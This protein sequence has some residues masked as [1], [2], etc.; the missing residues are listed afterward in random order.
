MDT[1]FSPFVLRSHVRGCEPIAINWTMPDR[2][3]TEKF[4][5]NRKSP[6]I[7]CPTRESNLQPLDQRIISSRLLSP[8]EVSR[9][10]L[11]NR[12]PLFTICVKVPCPMGC[13]PHCHIL[14]NA[15]LRATTETFLKYH[16]MARLLCPARESNPL[17][18]SQVESHLRPLDQQISQ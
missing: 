17:P 4:S 2:A 7:L 5:K 9:S 16:K 14:D 13:S 11:Y 10:T 12:H 3:T 8:K 1:H 15:R 18:H 6:T